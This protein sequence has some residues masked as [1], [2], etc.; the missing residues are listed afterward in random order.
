METLV[1]S[2]SSGSSAGEPPLGSPSA[3]AR[4]WLE[5]GP[6]GEVGNVKSVIRGH[7][8]C[9]SPPLSISLAPPASNSA[10]Q[11]A[12]P[13]PPLGVRAPPAPRG[14]ERARASA[15]V[16][17]RFFEGASKSVGG[18]VSPG[19]RQTQ[20]FPFLCFRLLNPLL[21]PRLAEDGNRAAA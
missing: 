9:S 21:K 11:G 17:G 8:M 4:R 20:T 6:P 10:G 14:G 1:A 5:Q 7:V 19:W 16:I 2:R 13:A 15:F 3:P 12:G 18:Q